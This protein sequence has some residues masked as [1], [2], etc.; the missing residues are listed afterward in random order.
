MKV[1]ATTYPAEAARTIDP[2]LRDL[3]DPPDRLD[4]HAGAA[5]NSVHSMFWSAVG[6]AIMI[7]TWT[8]VIVS[9]VES[10]R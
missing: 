9:C 8:F 4:A 5:P 6:I 10:A 3:P 7:V 1:G 2:D